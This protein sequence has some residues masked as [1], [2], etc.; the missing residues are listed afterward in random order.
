MSLSHALLVW[1]MFAVLA[2]MNGALRESVLVPSFGER[3]AHVLS[4]LIL[5]SVI[6]IVTEIGLPWMRVQTASD[7]WRVGVLWLGLTLAFEFLAGHF[8]FRVPWS[9]LVADYNVA[10]GRIWIL[11]L[12]AT[13]FAP[14]LAQHLRR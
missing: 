1:L 11:V 14:I 4:T 7:A 3:T 2:V 6:L 9:R 8:L 13:L 12:V 10:R 5:S